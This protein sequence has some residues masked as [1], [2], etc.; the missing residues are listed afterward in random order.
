MLVTRQCWAS[1][2]WAMQLSKVGPCLE[3]PVR[4]PPCKDQVH[5]A[6]SVQVAV[7]H[8]FFRVTC[9][10]SKSWEWWRLCCNWPRAAVAGLG[11]SRGQDGRVFHVDGPHPLKQGLGLPPTSTHVITECCQ[12]VPSQLDISAVHWL[13]QAGS[14]MG[15]VSWP[16]AHVRGR[17]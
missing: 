1:K 5:S 6:R 4:G 10:D 11:D 2:V 3:G 8:A 14:A 15:Q 7:T 9:W 17:G 12:T 13:D 16:A